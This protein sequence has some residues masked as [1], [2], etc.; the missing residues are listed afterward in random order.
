[1]AH[2]LIYIPRLAE[3][4]DSQL[5]KV[6]LAALRNS[7][8]PI[9]GT[10]VRQLGPD[11]GDG[12]IF[13]WVH[14]DA[15]DCDPHRHAQL[16]WTP[17][18]LN[19]A[20]GLKEGRYWFGVDPASRPT[21]DDLQLPHIHPG[22]DVRC[23]DNNFWHIPAAA[24][25]PHCHGMNA[26]GEWE[27]RIARQYEKFYTRAMRYG[28]ELFSEIDAFEA[29][30]QTMPEMQDS[31]HAVSVE[32]DDTDKHCCSALALNYRLTPEIIDLLGLLDDATMIAII[33]ATLDLPEIKEVL[34]QKK[35][36][37]P[38]GIPVG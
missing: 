32:L 37:S 19:K 2:Y 8:C 30:K 13:S 7:G 1:V 21:A 25:M 38:V 28:V 17:A 33:S 31:D 18:K 6:G 24:R 20:K 14:G 4:D 22:H 29:V 9:H 23:A 12:M 26:D 35:R 27:R 3:P 10:A 36:Y 16:E 11:D 15:R 5:E 34:N